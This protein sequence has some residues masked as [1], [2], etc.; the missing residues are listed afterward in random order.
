VFRWPAY[1]RLY[2]N[3]AGSGPAAPGVRERVR[4]VD[5]DLAALGGHSP[6][7]LE[8]AERL[9]SESRAAVASSLGLPSGWQTSFCW[10]A[11]DALNLV[12][13]AVV[14]RRCRL[15]ASDQE[16]PSGLLSLAVQRA[17]GLRVDLV[18]AE[19]LATWPERLAEARRTAD[20]VVVSLVAYSTG[21]RIAIER[22]PPPEDADG[23]LVVDVSQALGQV[24]LGAVWRAADAAVGLG[25]KWLH[26]PLPTGFVL[27][28]PRGRERLAVP[29]GGW[30]ARTSSSLFEADWR[31]DAAR[32]E[33]GSMDVARVAGLAV[34]LEHLPELLSPSARQR[35]AGYR[36]RLAE[37]VLRSGRTPIEGS[38]EGMLIYEVDRPAREVAAEV[39]RRGGAI[40]KDLNAPEVSDRIRISI[41]PLHQ[42]EEIEQLGELLAHS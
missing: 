6:A 38:V 23:L 30:H 10:S 22:V 26:G 19:P 9:L 21:W 4:A 18:A 8:L 32:F 42:D 12:A 20:L 13:S 14:P 33:P 29:R 7:G 24:D 31:T 2:F 35:V 11:T 17:R 41:C 36:A 40:I 34:V 37:A 5:D 3:Q 39:A 28:S 15:V 27:T 1:P 25:H 16:H